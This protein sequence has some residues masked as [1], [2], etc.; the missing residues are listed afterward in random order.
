V[1][2]LNSNLQSDTRQVTASANGFTDHGIFYSAAYTF[3]HVRD[4]SS[5]GGG[6]AVYGFTSATTAGNPNVVP[7]GTSDL[8]REHQ[9]VGTLT[10]PI[11][12]LI[13]LTAIAQVA[14]GTPY[15][16]LVNGD[17]NGD[18]ASR[19]DRAFVF[20]PTNPTTDPAVA[21]AMRTLLGSSSG[22]ISSCLSSQI[23]EIAER[24]S[25]VG[26][27][28]MSLNWQLN[29][30]PNIWGLDR[31]L[32][33]SLQALNSLTG[34][35]LLLHG[36]NH[37]QGWGQP[38]AP[39]ATLLTITG[40]DPGTNEYRYTV[41]THFGQ[42]SA[43]QS[44]GIPF[45]F[46]LA[47]RFAI[48]ESDAEQQLRGLFGGGRG[49]GGGPGGGPGGPAGPGGGGGGG[50]GAS[51]SDQRQSFADEIADRFAQRIQ[52]PF[53]AALKIKDALTLTDDEVTQIEASSQTFQIRLDSVTA[54]IRAQLK[55][56]GVN[57]D[58][59]SMAGIM[60]K[61]FTVVRDLTHSALDELQHELTP[62]QWLN[63][64]DSIKGT[65][66]GRPFGGG[67][68]GGGGGGRQPPP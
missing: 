13:E 32:T 51:S 46:V 43:N 34:L 59:G 7:W 55:K 37:L 19:N 4:Q 1:L 56:L 9:F 62:D 53:D 39:D 45:Q 36:P 33:I 30:R 47:G 16:P 3:S 41:N 52:N 44:Y 60:R 29:I 11:T 61:N 63:V 42:P 12:P 48:G 49:G 5:F 50:G 6:S 35:D 8:Q 68:G 15:T 27:W 17:V 58:M 20:D 64:P 21:S 57:V 2:S 66:T 67:R 22:R 25:C 40:F 10:Y 26:P 18:G 38:A 31:R 54:D 28:T 14:S 65:G 24:N 23:G